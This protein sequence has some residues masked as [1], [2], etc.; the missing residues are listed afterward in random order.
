M[1]KSCRNE[2][3]LRGKETA[4]KLFKGAFGKRCRRGG[5]GPDAAAGGCS[6]EAVQASLKKEQVPGRIGAFPKRKGAE[7]EGALDGRPHFPDK[8]LKDKAKN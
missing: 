4:P 1:G 6:F 5:K 7:D 2:G 3:L 8:G